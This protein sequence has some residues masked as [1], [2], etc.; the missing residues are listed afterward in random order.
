MKLLETAY[1][2][3]KPTMKAPQTTTPTSFA[4]IKDEIYTRDLEELEEVLEMVVDS[5]LK[6]HSEV[7]ELRELKDEFVEYKEVG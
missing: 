4:V 2:N 1:H 7:A 5:K 6:M 3:F